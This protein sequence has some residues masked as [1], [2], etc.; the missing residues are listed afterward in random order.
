[1]SASSDLASGTGGSLYLTP[2]PGIE[3]TRLRQEGLVRALRE[4]GIAV[5][6]PLAFAGQ[7]FAGAFDPAE[8]FAAC[9]ALLERPDRPTAV[10]CGND[11]LAMQVYNAAAGLGLGVPDDLSVVGF[12]DHRLIS[13]RKLRPALTTVALCLYVA[14]G[15][16]AV[17]VLL[18]RQDEPSEVAA[19]M[20]ARDPR[21]RRLRPP[22]RPRAL[23][24]M[25]SS[26]D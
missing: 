25:T 12:D 23:E 17:D 2:A 13:G 22:D 9:A 26:P 21:D 3:A 15:R 24:T 8:A 4:A 5:P 7:L 10:F 19:S 6:E 14:M 20:R 11:E 18:D 1:M 16:L